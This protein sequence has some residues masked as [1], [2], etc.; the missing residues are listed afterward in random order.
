MLLTRSNSGKA[1]VPIIYISKSNNII[2]GSYLSDYL[3]IN[4][5]II[6]VRWTSECV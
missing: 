4:F 1:L 5:Y 6:Q 2:M 3:Q